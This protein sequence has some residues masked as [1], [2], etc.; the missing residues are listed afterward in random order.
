MGGEVAVTEPEPVRLYPVGREFLFGV[1]GFVL[2]TPTTL[3]VDATTEGVH[4]G[5]QVR[6]DA[7][8]EH[9]RIITNIDHSGHFMIIGILSAVLPQAQ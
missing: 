3:G 2:V 6:A 1:P 9:P 5:V 8:P 7:D 4:A